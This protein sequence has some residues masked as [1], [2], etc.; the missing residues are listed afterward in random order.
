MC[1]FNHG[2][3]SSLPLLLATHPHGNDCNFLFL[4]FAS[5]LSFLPPFF[6]FS[7]PLPLLP[8]YTLQG[9]NTYLVGKGPSRI[10]IDTGTIVTLSSRTREQFSFPFRACKELFAFIHLYLRRRKGGVCSSLARCNGAE[11][12]QEHYTYPSHA[13]SS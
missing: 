2:N 9:T 5:V 1:T 13:L 3:T 8:S 10:L 12:M 7:S 6:P 4:F 11:R